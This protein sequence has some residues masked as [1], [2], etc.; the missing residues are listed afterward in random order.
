M[1][2]RKATAVPVI[3]LLLVGSLSLLLFWFGVLAGW[4]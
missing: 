1:H 2:V 3:L 4:W